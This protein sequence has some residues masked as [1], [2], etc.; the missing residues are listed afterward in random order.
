MRINKFTIVLL[1]E[2]LVHSVFSDACTVKMR[3][4]EKWWGLCNDFGREMPFTE[5]TSF[6]CDLRLNNYSHQSLSFLC[7]DKGR[8]IWCAEPI[9]VK[10]AGGEIR[11]ESDKGEIVI[12][13]DA[14]RNLGE[15]FRYASKTWFPPTGEEPELLYFSAPQYNTW[16]ELTYHQNEKD[17]LAYAQSMLDNGLPPGILMIDDTWQFDYGEWYFDPRRFSDPKGMMAKLHEMGYKVLLW[18]CPFVSMD[19]PAFRRIAF[20]YNPDDVNGYPVKGG[21][22][23]ASKE[24]GVHRVPPAAAVPWWN[25]YSALLDFTH[26]NAVAWFTEQLERLVEDYGADGFKFDGGGVEFY[27]S[28][29]GNFIAHDE[30]VSPAAQSALYGNFA[31][32]Y[33]GSEYRNG[34]GFAGKPV[35]MR[36]HDKAHSWDALRRLV[37][38]MWAAGF[39]GCPFICPDMI[40]GGSWKAFLPG[41]PFDPELFVRSAQV[42]ALCPMMQFSA[43]PWR[44]LDAEN[45]KIVREAVALRQKFAGKIV[46][47]AKASSRTGEPMLRNLEYNFPGMGYADIKDQF[48]MGDDLLVAPVVEKGAKS[49]KVVL[50][51][52]K[53]KADDGQ[54]HAGPATI[55]IPTPLSR[56]PY[57]VCL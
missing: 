36:L 19:S 44:V 32:K 56:L 4:G 29:R 16:I 23:L 18:M 1:M 50:P 15:A 54:I 14:G 51:P 46:E 25:G 21:F 57:F 38:D 11:L 17:I 37:S 5:K 22:L 48:M 55:E 45:Q 2:C 43:S 13:D 6:S 9:G 39:V 28:V 35:I 20:G 42:H 49:R 26:P 27:S 31:V 33:K 41:A 47:L 52:G 8:V 10:I 7:S 3:Q 30:S 12:K 53:W 24:K 40:G 34:F